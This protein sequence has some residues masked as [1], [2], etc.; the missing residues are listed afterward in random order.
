M[1]DRSSGSRGFTL[2]ELIIVIAVIGIL[3]T[4]AIPMLKNTPRRAVE[5]A[6]KHDLRV[7]RELLNEYKADKGNYPVSLE[8]L[9]TEGYIKEIPDDPITK[10]AETWV[11]VYEPYDPDDPPTEDDLTEEGQ[12]GIF[13]IKSGSTETPLDGEG[14]YQDW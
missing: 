11:L 13:D 12:P 10:S 4:I 8:E 5:T 3:A 7:M 6:L 2:M 14:T 9:V 1:L